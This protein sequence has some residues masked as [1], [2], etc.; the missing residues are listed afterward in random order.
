MKLINPQQLEQKKSTIFNLRQLHHCKRKKI[1][2]EFVTWNREGSTESK[3][4][5]LLLLEWVMTSHVQKNYWI[6]LLM[7]MYTDSKKH[8]IGRLPNQNNTCLYKTQL[9]YVQCTFSMASNCAQFVFQEFFFILFLA[10]CKC[11][12]QCKSLNQS[13][14]DWET[15]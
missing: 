9:L 10:L 1:C 5:A 8:Y 14:I 4:K 7:S 15:D 12:H 13:L 6:Y 3:N 2:Y 11:P